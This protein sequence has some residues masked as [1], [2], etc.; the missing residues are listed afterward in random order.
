M[1]ELITQIIDSWRVN[2]RMNLKILEA[3]DSE[4]LNARPVSKRK[5]KTVAEQFAHLNNVRLAYLEILAKDYI[6]K[7]IALEKRSKTTKAV[8]KKA[9]IQSAKAV[10]NY[11]RDALEGKIKIKVIKSPVMWLGYLI[12][13]D[14]HH[15]GSILLALKQ[16]GRPVNQK[17]QYGI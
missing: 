12:S 14:S 8:I 7:P 10:E 13:H 2:N 5:V 16:S 9:L 1:N 3:I 6:K 4:G 11:L 15:R 17:V